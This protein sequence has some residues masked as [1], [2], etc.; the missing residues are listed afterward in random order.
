M[1]VGA[2]WT[3]R[4]IAQNITQEGTHD[5][6]VAGV[7]ISIIMTMMIVMMIVSQKWW[8]IATASG[9][10]FGSVMFFAQGLMVFISILVGVAATV[11]MWHAM[12][13]SMEDH[14]RL[15]VY[16]HAHAGIGRVITAVAFIISAFVYT[17][18]IERD[19]ATLMLSNSLR[20]T[21]T[22]PIARLILPAPLA[23]GTGVNG[24]VT[25]DDFIVQV[26][27]SQTQQDDQ[28]NISLQFLENYAGA[29]GSRLKDIMPTQD[30][31]RKVHASIPDSVVAQ[32]RAELSKELGMPLTG[33]EVVADIFVQSLEKQIR[34]FAEQK[35][36][37]D[38]YKFSKALAGV[39]AFF[40]FLSLGWI[41]TF[42]KIVWMMTAQIVVAV[43][44][45]MGIVRIAYATVQKEYIV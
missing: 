6:F 33:K 5:W 30:T 24:E 37:P 22:G 13:R 11:S 43:L 34:L 1:L 3:W 45:R 27:D 19:A 21:A 23:N 39:I 12:R 32:A 25:V 36:L 31:R 41:G 18:I 42:L 10:A 20:S 16:T 14:V 35:I 2:L 7:A 17:I 8:H 29:V 4:T 40:L 9:I 26:L 38:G 44:R 15:R 28:K